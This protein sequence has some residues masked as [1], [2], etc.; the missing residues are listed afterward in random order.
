MFLHLLVMMGQS[1][2]GILDLPS[3]FIQLRR[4]QKDQRRSVYL[5]STMRSLVV[6]QTVL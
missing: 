4:I 1:K 2:F 6:D 3:P 5:L